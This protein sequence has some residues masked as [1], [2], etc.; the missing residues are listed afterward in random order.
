[1]SASTSHR[2]SLLIGLAALTTVVVA[3]TPAGATSPTSAAAAPAAGTYVVQ[4]V[5]GASVDVLVDG[6]EI[7]SGVAAKQ[8]VGSLDLSPG[9]HRFTFRTDDWEVSSAVD[10]SGSQDVVLHW[11]A[12]AADR[13]VVTVFANDV[14]AVGPGKGRL[15]VAHTAVVPPADIVADG[16]TLFTNIANGEFVSAV[17]PTSTYEVAVVP[18]GGGDPLLG[19]L[20]LPVA[21]GQLTRVFA[22]GAPRD[23]TMDAVVQ[24]LPVP[25]T[26]E[27][28][29]AVDTGA[30]GLVR[31]DGSV[32]GTRLALWWSLVALRGGLP[33]WWPAR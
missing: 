29:A 23:G 4:G 26:G 12:D 5:P 18:T 19:P 33:G 17:V 27:R 30:A 11:P 25:T 1:M 28:P 10:T 21:A 3:G 31:L 16:Q 13:P 32:D 6:D 9:S 8:V 7:R 24:T 20:D 2:T 15:T 14:S 22:I